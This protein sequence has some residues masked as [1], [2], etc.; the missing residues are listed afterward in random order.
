M[1]LRGFKNFPFYRQ[2]DIMDYGPTCLKMIAAYYGKEYTTEELRVKSYITR[3]G[4]SLAGI[5]EA[6]EEIGFHALPVSTTIDSL[7]KEIPLPCIAHWRQGHFIVV[8]KI[9]KKKV[10][11]GDPGHGIMKYLCYFS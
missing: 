3:E 7:K 8:Y 9:T 11:V 2:L 5:A 10:V 1:I 4:V 6:A